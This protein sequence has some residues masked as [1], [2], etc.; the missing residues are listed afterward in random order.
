MQESDGQTL[1]QVRAHARMHACVHKRARRRACTHTH[2]KHLNMIK[3]TAH[4]PCHGSHNTVSTVLYP[5][6][7]WLLVTGCSTVVL[8]FTPH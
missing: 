5:T 7:S 8:T 3:F 4:P 2:T 1:R 6:S